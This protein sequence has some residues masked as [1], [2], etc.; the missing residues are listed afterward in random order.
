VHI[1]RSLLHIFAPAFEIHGTPID[2]LERRHRV[3][4]TLLHRAYSILTFLQ[5]LDRVSEAVKAA[6][7][8]QFILSQTQTILFA[9]EYRCLEDAKKESVVKALFASK[10]PLRFPPSPCDDATTEALI[11][12]ELAEEYASFKYEFRKLTTLRNKLLD[13]YKA[14]SM[15]SCCRLLWSLTCTQLGPLVLVDRV[16][17]I[18]LPKSKIFYDVVVGVLGHLEGMDEHPSAASHFEQ[19]NAVAGIAHALA[20]TDSDKVVARLDELL[21]HPNIQFRYMSHLEIT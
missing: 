7:S 9:Y 13:C 11:T 3:S 16:W 15:H 10:N 1:D 6:E 21:Q 17:D 20:G 5:T 12:T 2:L 14:V 4:I 19:M 8:L 18:H